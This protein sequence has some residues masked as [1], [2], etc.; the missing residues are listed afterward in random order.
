[1]KKLILFILLMLPLYVEAQTSGESSYL[2]GIYALEGKN[3][4][5]QD[6]NKAYEYI[7]TA[8]IISKVKKKITK[9][10]S[11][12]CFL[13]IDDL[14]GSFEVIVFEATYNKFGYAIEEEKIVLIE[15]RLSV[16][17]DEPTKIVASTIKEMIADED[18]ISNIVVDITD[19]SEDKKQELREAIRYYAKQPN[20]EV[21][22]EVLVNG[23]ARDCGK[24]FADKSV[25]RKW[26][27][28]FGESN[29]KIS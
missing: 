10:N 29:I 4:Y 17:E 14:Y 1:M 18:T 5:L 13:T 24:I 15:G 16:R 7:K 6:I 21:K 20:S 9:N 26:T 2:K 3:G 22:V 19:F 25:V 12:M 23:E 8:G 27:E 28:I 11:V